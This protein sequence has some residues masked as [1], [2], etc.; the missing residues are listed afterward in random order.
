MSGQNQEEVRAIFNL[1]DTN[2]NNNPQQNSEEMD[3]R[4]VNQIIRQI[5]EMNMK[6]KGVA[7]YQL[8]EARNN[9]ENI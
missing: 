5:D 6:A 1:F 4:Q 7:Q 8:E 3:I 2:N 9:T